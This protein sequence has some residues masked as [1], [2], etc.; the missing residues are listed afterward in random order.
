MS[1]LYETLGV[2]RTASQDEI[3]KAFKKLAR[4][5][6]PDINKEAGAEERFKEVNAAYDMLGDPEKRK[7]Y[8]EFGEIAT[9]P[10]F[11]A[12][13]ARAWQRAGQGFPGGAG[14]GGF[15]FDFGEGA[16][17]MEDFFS[18][19]FGGGFGRAPGAPKPSGRPPTGSSAR[20]GPRAGRT[21]VE[22]DFS[23][24]ANGFGG[25]R[26]HQRT[27]DRGHDQTMALT[28]DAM[29]AILGGERR[30]G[31]QRPNGTVDQL[32]V[33]IPAGARDGGQLKLK[34]QGLPPVGG[35]ACG[36]L[37]LKLTV[38]E[39]PVLRRKDDDLEMDVPITILEAMEGAVITV[40]TPT[41]DVKVT[42]PAGSE[43]GRKLRLKGRGVQKRTEPGDLYLVL[44]IVPLKTDDADL[45]AAARKIHE[46][47]GDVRAAI[48]L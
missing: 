14:A 8:D 41:G 35:G 17:D 27:S 34:G 4:T 44:S 38:A 43:S 47:Q 7:L 18:Q 22:S 1:N 19:I 6:H 12:E 24:F 48:K 32:N 20:S 42:V 16:V 23:G 5:Y 36:D 10:G 21:R 25:A 26:F 39:H 15:H 31:V 45:K 37:I 46:A 40:P 11:D 29:T 2:S 3:K 28:I 9:K 13:K 33:R 30:L